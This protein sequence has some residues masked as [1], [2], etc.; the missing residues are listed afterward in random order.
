MLN[1]SSVTGSS[2]GL[3]RG[4]VFV[5]LALSLS[6]CAVGPIAGA[7][8]SLV[9]GTVTAAADVTSSVVGGAVDIVTPDKN[10]ETSE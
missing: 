2:R 7:A 1:K 9:S 5:L 8:V 3:G 6:G 4:F 10:Q